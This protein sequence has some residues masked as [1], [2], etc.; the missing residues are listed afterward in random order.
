[1]LRFLDSIVTGSPL[2]FP[3]ALSGFAETLAEDPPTFFKAVSKPFLR[4]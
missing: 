3:G 1:M 2:L 4:F